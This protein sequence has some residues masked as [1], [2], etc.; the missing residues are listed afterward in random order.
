LRAWLR[1]DKPH[2]PNTSAVAFVRPSIVDEALEDEIARSR[3]M[4]QLPQDWDDQGAVRIDE[5]TWSRAISFLRSSAQTLRRIHGVAMPV[6]QISPS[7]DGSIDILWRNPT[8]ELL[9]NITAT[10]GGFYGES[11]SGLRIK[12]T[13]FPER[14]DQGILSWLVSNG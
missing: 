6:P 9:I 4:L 2:S 5:S 1:Q 14:Q 3:E 10:E 13:F 12:G 7:P 11:K 8:F